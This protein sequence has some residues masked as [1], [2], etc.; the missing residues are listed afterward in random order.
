MTV[1][2][3]DVDAFLGELEKDREDIDRSIV[4]CVY[5]R[6]SRQVFE[7]ISVVATARI[8]SDT[9]ELRVDVGD[10]WP[11]GPEDVNKETE[12]LAEATAARIEKFCEKHKLELRGGHY[13]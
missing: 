5:L 9:V 6:E 13:T 7:R 8:H 4:R 1:A 2:F 11:G 12:R 10:R 3:N